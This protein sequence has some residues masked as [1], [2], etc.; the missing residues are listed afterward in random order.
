MPRSE[1]WLSGSHG[2]RK[3][4]IEA[5]KEKHLASRISSRFPDSNPTIWNSPQFVTE[6]AIERSDGNL[7]KLAERFLRYPGNSRLFS[8]NPRQMAALEPKNVAPPRPRQVE[9]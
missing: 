7:V 4:R 2:S 8:F 6:L 3:E 9:F 5:G 1:V